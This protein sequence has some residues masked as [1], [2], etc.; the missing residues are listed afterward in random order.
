[1][2]KGHEVAEH[3]VGINAAAERNVSQDGVKGNG[4]A[5]NIGKKVLSSYHS[6]M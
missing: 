2:P 5:V 1:M 3:P 4:V 6:W